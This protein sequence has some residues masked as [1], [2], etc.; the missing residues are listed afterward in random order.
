MPVN[1]S[2]RN[3]PDELAARLRERAGRNHRSLQGELV[4]I[5]EDATRPPS[6]GLEDEGRE[7][8]AADPPPLPKGKLSMDDAL[9]Y[10]RNLGLPRPAQNESTRMIREDRDD[11][12]RP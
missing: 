10:I 9:A 2:I 12:S 8:R 1:L 6:K 4:A 11:P 3:V 7:F 5:L